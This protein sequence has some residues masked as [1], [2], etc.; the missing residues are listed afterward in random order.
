M[1]NVL[2]CR[3]PKNRFDARAAVTCRP[4]LDRQLAL[5]AP[6]LLVPLGAVALRA[7]APDAPRILL[8]AGEPL[9]GGRPSIFPLIHPAAALRSR[10]LRERW[11][12]DVAAL[13]AYLSDAA[14]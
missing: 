12:R 6:E 13:A 3:P 11:D 10:S 4:F 7:L 1:L 2:K 8:V 14:R 5:L 9:P